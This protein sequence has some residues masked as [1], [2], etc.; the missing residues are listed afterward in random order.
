[1]TSEPDPYQAP[2]AAPR[3][4]APPTPSG[5]DVRAALA[6]ILAALIGVVG[7]SLLA[8][9]RLGALFSV[10]LPQA[11]VIIVVV[12]A[13]LLGRWGAPA[14][15]LARPRLRHLAAGAALA[16]AMAILAVTLGWLSFVVLGPPPPAVA[17]IEDMLK[18]IREVGGWAVLAATTC[19]LPGLGEEALFRG[20]ILRGFRRRMPAWAAVAAAALAFAILHLS[21]WR[22]LPQLALGLMVGTLAIRTGSCWP[23]AVTHA[24]YNLLTMLIFASGDKHIGQAVG[25][26]LI[27]AVPGLWLAGRLLRED[28]SRA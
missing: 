16:P 10:L 20:L 28:D 25:G 8:G 1:M 26:I 12:A 21:P 5:P 17:R 14:A 9:P 19:V 13:M 6:I 11:A 18:T 2:A 23:G 24:C 7:G 3:S 27:V 15:G 4:S 22:F